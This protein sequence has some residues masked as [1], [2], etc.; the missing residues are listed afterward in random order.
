MINFSKNNLIIYSLISILRRISD[1]EF[2]NQISKE[3]LYTFLALLDFYYVNVKERIPNKFSLES[4][5]KKEYYVEYKNKEEEE[6]D[7]TI[8]KEITALLGN[9]MIIEENVRIFYEK[10]LQLILVDNIISFIN[11]PKIVKICVG[12]LINLT[13]REIIRDSLGNVAAYIQSL[14]FV[15]ETYKTNSAITDY[16]LKLLVNSIKNSKSLFLFIIYNFS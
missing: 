6:L 1:K 13:S 11:Y 7:L 12:T 16:L 2:L 14:K 9:L 4:D 15:M 8:L 5:N 10:N 3:F